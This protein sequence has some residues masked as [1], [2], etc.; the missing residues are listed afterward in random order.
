MSYKV[1]SENVVI[2]PDGSCIPCDQGN[3]HYVEYLAWLAE[4]NEP[5]EWNDG[6]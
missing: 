3:R 1:Y 5:E 4:G 6:N 2:H